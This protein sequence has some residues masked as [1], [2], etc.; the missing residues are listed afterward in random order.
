MSDLVDCR[1]CFGARDVSGGAAS[2]VGVAVI[3]LVG[4]PGDGSSWDGEVQLQDPV[5][6]VPHLGVVYYMVTEGEVIR[7]YRYSL[8]GVYLGPGITTKVSF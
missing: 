6:I 2:W 4:G 5:S 7:Q 1:V 3:E 8:D